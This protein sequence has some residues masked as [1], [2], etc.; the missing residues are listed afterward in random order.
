MCDG[1][2]CYRCFCSTS[3][4]EVPSFVCL[5]AQNP[6]GLPLGMLVHYQPSLV[7]PLLCSLM[8]PL[9][10]LYT[11]SLNTPHTTPSLS[12]SPLS[13]SFH[14]CPPPSHRHVLSLSLSSTVSLS[15]SLSGS[16]VPFLRFF[17]PS[18]AWPIFL[19]SPP[20]AHALVRA[21]ISLSL[22]LFV[23]VLV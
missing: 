9:L 3:Y 21:L 5:R 12:L 4:R 7:Y 23:L 16:L 20:L 8:R 22:S 6:Q 17:C 1:S 11:I 14:L 18:L 15:V 19:L 2:Q 10:L 13:L